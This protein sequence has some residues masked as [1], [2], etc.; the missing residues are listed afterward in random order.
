MYRKYLAPA[1]KRRFKKLGMD[2]ELGSATEGF[3]VTFYNTMIRDLRDYQFNIIKNWKTYT[4]FEKAQIRRVL[5]E[6]GI[7]L[8]LT[9]LIYILKS[10]IPDDDDDPIKDTYMY[11]FILY[12]A[13]RMRSETKQNVPG[14]G[15]PDLWKTIKSPSAATTSIDRIVKFADQAFVSIYDAD[16]RAYKRKTGV[17]EKGDSKTWAYFLKMMG[18]TG[19]NFNPDQA[20][21]SFESIFNR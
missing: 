20:V 7:V 5:A 8:A 11:N 19:N 3:Y 4:P 13:I 17:W 21:K 18:Y 12:Q 16:A 1:Y 6:L 2:Y 9:A 14:V 15:L 10:V